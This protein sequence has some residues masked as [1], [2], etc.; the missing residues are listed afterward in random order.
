M[1]ALQGTLPRNRCPVRVHEAVVVPVR[2]AVHVPDAYRISRRLL[3]MVFSSPFRPC[4]GG[5]EAGDR[6]TRSRY[7][8]PSFGPER[9]Q[10]DLAAYG[11]AIGICRIRRIRK[12]LGIRCKQIKKF[13]ATTDSKHAL[14][15]ADNLL[16]QKLEAAAPGQ[17]WVSDI[18]YIPTGE[19]WLYCAAHKD[20]FNGEIMGYALGPRIIKDLVIRSLLMA[21]KS[22]RPLPGFVNH[23]DRGRQYCSLEYRRLLDQFGMM[24]HEQEG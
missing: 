3:H 20:L 21:V 1:Y 5:S 18:T 8:N 11:V 23:S 7:K 16:K 13:K 15:V 17:I 10:Y 9:L 2:P 24:V 22:K 14:P 6:D 19:G 4:A 12:K